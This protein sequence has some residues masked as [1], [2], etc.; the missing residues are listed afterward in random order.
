M[1]FTKELEL[2]KKIDIILP[3]E[4]SDVSSDRHGN[5]YVCG[6]GSP[7]HVF[8]KSGQFL[9]SFAGVK[10]ANPL[11]ICV[12]GDYVYV[13]DRDRNDVLAYT[14]EGEYVTSFKQHSNCNFSSPYGV[15]ADKD[16]FVYICDNKRVLVF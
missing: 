11:G 10:L 8:T 1:V 4:L 2:V 14:T 16:G 5:L 15:Y 3:E 12:T 6:P 7:V 9:R 13:T